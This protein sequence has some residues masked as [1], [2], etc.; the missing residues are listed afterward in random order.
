MQNEF[1]PCDAIKAR[2]QQ[3]ILQ[4]LIDGGITSLEAREKFGVLHCAGRVLELRKAGYSI[5]TRKVVQ[6]DTEGR[7]H[8]V[9]MYVLG[10]DDHA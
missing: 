2:Q 6:T 3:T 4:A 5:V 7:R 1:V 8:S 10:G 9:A